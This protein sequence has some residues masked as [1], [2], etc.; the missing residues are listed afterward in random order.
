MS[1]CVENR[2]AALESRAEALIQALVNDYRS[3]EFR[4]P[5]DYISLGII[6]YPAI[7]KNPMDLSTVKVSLILT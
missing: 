3:V 5:V 4:Q 2:D 7:I 6:D 1:F